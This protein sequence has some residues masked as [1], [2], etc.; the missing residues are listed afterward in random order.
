MTLDL[1]KK[2]RVFHMPINAVFLA[3]FAIHLV[4]VVLFWHW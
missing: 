2:W 1:M 3:L 4:T